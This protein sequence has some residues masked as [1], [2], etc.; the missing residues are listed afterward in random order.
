MEKLKKKIKNKKI[1]KTSK[2]C[3]NLL[4]D[5]K[6]LLGTFPKISKTDHH[7]SQ[8]FGSCF[9]S[10]SNGPTHVPKLVGGRSLFAP[11]TS[12]T[13]HSCKTRAQS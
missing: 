6:T 2:S 7:L 4:E 3:R 12:D 1:R 11:T 10:V 9:A 8:L 13:N 5:S